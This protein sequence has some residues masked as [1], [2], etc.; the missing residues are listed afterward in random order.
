MA[1]VV[2]EEVVKSIMQ[3]GL[4]QVDENLIISEFECAFDKESRKLR[5]YFKAIN[6]ENGENIEINK[7]Y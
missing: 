5:V 1:N 6:K 3:D 7:V 2:S 4:T